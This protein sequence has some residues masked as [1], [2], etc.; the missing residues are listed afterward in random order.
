MGS[1]AHRAVLAYANWQGWSSAGE[2]TRGRSIRPVTMGLYRGSPLV[3]QSKG[4]LRSAPPSVSPHGPRR[5]SARPH[6]LPGP[7][8]DRGEA[9]SPRPS[10]GPETAWS[11][12]GG[13]ISPYQAEPGYQSS[14]PIPETGGRRGVPDVSYDAD[15]NTGFLVY[16]ST[17]Y[18]GAAGW[19]AVGGT[20][21]GAP[22][23][24]A[25]TALADQ[26]RLSALSSNNTSSSPQYNAA[27][28]PAYAANYRDITTGSN[29]SCGSAR[30]ASTGYDFVTGLGSPVA[31]ALVPYLAT[32]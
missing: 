1:T 21:A 13:G 2:A 20:S 14:Y 27:T 5:P 11:G 30:T 9:A 22:Q 6:S 23:W 3:C 4:G 32:S 25:L 12:S 17:R 26:L 18:L 16:D 10:P 29:G 7:G 24:A 8:L 28:G 19:W 31:N 15:P